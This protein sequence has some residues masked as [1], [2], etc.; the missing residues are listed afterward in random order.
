MYNK[1]QIEV[2]WKN[3]ITSMTKNIEKWHGKKHGKVA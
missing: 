1:A 3:G 2:E